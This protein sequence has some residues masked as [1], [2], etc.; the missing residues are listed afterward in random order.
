MFGLVLMTGLIGS[1]IF[2]VIIIALCVV[3]G[4]A[5]DREAE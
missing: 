2:G 5:D 1:T 3:A 4:E